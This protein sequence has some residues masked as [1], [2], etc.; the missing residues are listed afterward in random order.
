MRQRRC[1][2]NLTLRE[3]ARRLQW[4]A[5]Y[6]SYLERGLRDWSASRMALYEAALE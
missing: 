4:S 1:Q 2:A 3:M 5:T 6:V